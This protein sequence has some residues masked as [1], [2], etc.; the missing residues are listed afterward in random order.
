VRMFGLGLT[1]AIPADATLVRMVLLP[2]FMHVM[3]ERSGWSPRWLTRLH[4]RIGIDDDGPRTDRWSVRN[5]TPRV[6]EC[7]SGHVSR[8]TRSVT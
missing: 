5:A 6:N 7:G 8:E 4:D 2:A 3:G 1:L